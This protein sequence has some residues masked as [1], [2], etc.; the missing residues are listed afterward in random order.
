MSALWLQLQFIWICLPLSF[1]GLANYDFNSDFN[2]PSSWWYLGLLLLIPLAW[3]VPRG[4]KYFYRLQL[5]LLVV[6]S[7]AAYAPLHMH[8]W[9]ERSLNQAIVWSFLCL[10]SWNLARMAKP[11]AVEKSYSWLALWPLAL[12]WAL[13]SQSVFLP[14]LGILIIGL[15]VLFSEPASMHKK[16]AKSDANM[17]TYSVFLASLALMLPIYDL[18]VDPHA[19]WVIALA[20]SFMPA[21]YWLSRIGLYGLVE[22]AGVANFIALVLSPDYALDLLC[23]MM[24]AIWLGA[25]WHNRQAAEVTIG[26]WAFVAFMGYLVAII[27]ARNL[28]LWTY[29]LWLVL[30]WIGFTVWHWVQQQRS[31][32]MFSE[33]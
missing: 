21:G 24:N 15:F 17:R 14:L 22:I 31:Q 11:S 32:K 19:A 7:A 25:L 29:Q 18:H 27:F 4:F 20:L 9:D 2:S 13:A 5:L 26:R 16:P 33:S 1:I 23:L 6:L 28:I 8:F 3:L 30:P 10:L 12:L